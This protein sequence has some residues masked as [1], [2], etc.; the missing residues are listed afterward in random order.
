[1]K[2]EQD[3]VV[4]PVDRRR[5]VTLPGE[6]DLYLASVAADGTITLAPAV[7]VPAGRED[8]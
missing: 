2:D 4:V 8:K 7:I 3:R 6:H 5:R 1:M